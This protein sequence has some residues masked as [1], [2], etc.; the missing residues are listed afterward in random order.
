MYTIV[1]ELHLVCIL[2]ETKACVNEIQLWCAKI[3]F[4][5]TNFHTG[6]RHYMTLTLLYLCKYM[7]P[8]VCAERSSQSK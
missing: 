1:H 4:V 8:Y 5:L 6:I 2:N 7:R 3:Y